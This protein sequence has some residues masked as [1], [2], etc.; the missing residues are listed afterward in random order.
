[1]Q[2]VLDAWARDDTPELPIYPAGSSGP[3]EAD[4]LLGH[5]GRRWRSLNGAI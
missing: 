4:A 3:S 5:D 2:P 1:V